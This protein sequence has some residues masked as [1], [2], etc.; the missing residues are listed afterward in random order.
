LLNTAPATMAPTISNSAPANLNRGGG[1]HKPAVALVRGPSASHKATAIAAEMPSGGAAQSAA[2]PGAESTAVRD[3]GG[4]SL[5]GPVADR[6]VIE[7]MMPS[8]PTWA[9]GQGVEASVTLYFL[10]LPSG[11]VKENIQVQRT[12]G[13]KDFDANAVA[14][15]KSWRFAPLLENDGRQQWGT[16]TFRF[17]LSD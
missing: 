8:Y 3:L 9:T 4:A 13:Y 17:R 6:K 2:T 15:L 11:H 5:A 10:V 12:A 14:A 7:F 1:E 16:I